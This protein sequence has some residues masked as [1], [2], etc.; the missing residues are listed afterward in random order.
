MNPSSFGGRKGVTPFQGLKT[1]NSVSAVLVRSVLAQQNI[2][3]HTKDK[4]FQEAIK[5]QTQI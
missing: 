1:V 5:N 4:N 3:K 2:M